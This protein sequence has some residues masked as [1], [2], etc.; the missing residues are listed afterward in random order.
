MWKVNAEELRPEAGN[1]FSS[2]SNSER[3]R[4]VEIWMRQKW[5]LMPWACTHFTRWEGDKE[6]F[7]GNPNIEETDQAHEEVWHEVLV[8]ERNNWSPVLFGIKINHLHYMWTLKNWKDSIKFSF[9]EI[10]NVLSVDCYSFSNKPESSQDPG[11]ECCPGS[12]WNQ[13]TQ[14]PVCNCSV[15]KH[16][17]RQK[18]FF[19]QT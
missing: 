3:R 8:K 4:A 7:L 19:P 16:V 2:E 10:D 11:R 1:W 13:V 6:R 18:L 14:R 17:D 15:Q 12:W 5:P 9:Q